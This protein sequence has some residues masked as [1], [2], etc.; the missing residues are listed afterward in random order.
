MQFNERETAHILAA[1]RISDHLEIGGMSHFVG[2]EGGPLTSDEIDDLAERINLD[3][4][5]QGLRPYTVI[6]LRLDALDACDYRE[7]TFIWHVR[8]ASPET[9]AERAV[10]EADAIGAETA[11]L[12]V[13]EGLYLNDVYALNPAPNLP[14]D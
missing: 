12:A 14:V 5:K 13:F 10:I 7:A 9:A 3:E 4:V 8:A 11:I 1:L 6:G 2:V